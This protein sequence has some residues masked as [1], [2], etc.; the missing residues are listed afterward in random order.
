[1][2]A[3]INLTPLSAVSITT[4]RVDNALLVLI[5]EA[6]VCHDEGYWRRKLTSILR[7]GE[8]LADI[9]S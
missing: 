5:N 6:F 7:R 3:C 4:V 2:K 9:K 1:M 8:P